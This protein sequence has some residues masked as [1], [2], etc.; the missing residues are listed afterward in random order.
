MADRPVKKQSFLHGAA[1]LA[2]ATLIVK[3][4]GMLY[5]IPLGNIIGDA[6]YG[7][8]TTAY[9]IYSVLLMVSTTGL[10][11]A[12]S[13]MIS[14]ARALGN[15]A[16]CRRIFRTALYVFL[17]LGVV[18]SAGMLL[19]CR[20]LSVMATGFDTSWAA[21]AF[22]A[23]SVLFICLISAFRGFFQ[24]QSNMT[25]TS[26]SQ[27]FEALCKLGV[28][29]LAAWLLLKKTG[30]V[31]LA[32]GGAI[33]GVTTGCVLSMLYLWR[34]YSKATSGQNF[35]GG[36]VLPVSR[37]MKTLLAIAVP[38]TLG[39]AGLQLI[40]LADTMVFMR[41]LTGAAGFAQLAAENAKGIYNFCQTIFNLP[42]AFIT[43]ITISIIPAITEHLTCKNARGAAMVE[44]S[45]VRIMSL[46]ALPC[47]VGLA[48]LSGPILQLLRGYEGE[49]LV[50]GG[51]ILAILGAAVVFNSL[52]LLTNAIMQARGHVTR[53]VIHMLIG[54][55][56]KV[57]VNYVLVGIPSLNIVGAPIGTLLCYI[58]ITALNLISMRR[59]SGEHRAKIGSAMLKPFLA[60][61]VMGVAAFVVYDLLSGFIPSQKLVCLA[62]VAIAGIVYLI[63]VFFLRVITYEDC[64]LL[65]KGEKI[66]RLL[67]ISQ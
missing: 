25:P 54:G 19:F 38:I 59:L 12:M 21:I 58:V 43:P 55:V 22:L 45:A 24:G 56:V 3:V 39:S 41:R 40:N 7:Y 52:V 26:V 62:A 11:V 47:A 37:T 44:S 27:V 14:E 46:I 48:V 66:A 5:K 42:C 31:T 2:L 16:Q 49:Q 61:A 32:A 35:A 20:Q 53:P 33:L 23:P 18:G 29:L 60:A 9:D 34:C 10:P 4:I 6:G 30:D 64:L 36:E 57:A 51:R 50:T 28:G 8:F 13:R 67:R 65:P 15:M 63:S 1:V 17:L